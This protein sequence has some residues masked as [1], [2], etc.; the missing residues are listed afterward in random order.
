LPTWFFA[1]IGAEGDLTMH[2]CLTKSSLSEPRR[3]LVE[4]VQRI[5]FGRIEQ[6]QIRRGDPVLDP[7]PRI[8]REH[9]F[10]GENGPRPELAAADFALKTQLIELFQEFDRLRDAT[11]AVLEI[12][13]GL[14]FRMLLAESV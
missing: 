8:T 1:P 11:I 12:K 3:W 5:S 10:G 6:L 9:R 2:R 13:H 4:L 7:P 14:P